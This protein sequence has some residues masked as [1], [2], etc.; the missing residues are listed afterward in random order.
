MTEHILSIV[1]VES[2]LRRSKD[3]SE[4]FVLS[5][6]L[7]RNLFEYDI[8][9][10]FIQEGGLKPVAHSDLPHFDTKSP[11]VKTIL[12]NLTKLGTHAE[13][14]IYP[15]ERLFSAFPS[16]GIEFVMVVPLVRHSDRKRVGALVFGTKEGFS[17]EA[18]VIAEHCAETLVLVL[19]SLHAVRRIHLPPLLKYGAVLASLTAISMI[20]VHVSTLG[21]AQVVAAEPTIVT[22][23]INGIV[24]KVKVKSNDQVKRGDWLLSFDDIEYRGK[25]KIA[26]QTIN[27]SASEIVKQERAA[28]FDPSIKNRLEESRAERAVKSMEYKAISSELKKLTVYAPA[29]GI[30]LL[31]S[32][33]DLIGKP[34]KAGEKLLSIVTPENVEVEVLVSAHESNVIHLGD[35]VNIYLD[36]NPLHPLEGEI[37]KIYYEPVVAP[38]NLLSYKAYARLKNIDKTP[39]IGMCGNMKI[40]GEEIT[41]FWYLFRKPI[42]YMRWYFG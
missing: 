34:V 33:L 35:K 4:A 25:Q 39:S 37:Y 6:N 38:S 7:L 41:L 13:A 23:P 16:R 20:P 5:V 8:A 24:K 15:S 29:E 30:V 3:T 40:K 11:Y 17:K 36:H 18:K 27:I 12:K 28:F 22:A 21:K 2:R 14:E 19:S 9:M 26:A 31:D 32:P 42:A 10:G 1:E